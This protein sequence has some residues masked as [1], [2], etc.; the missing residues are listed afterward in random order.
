MR[1]FI[2]TLNT[3]ATTKLKSYL[4]DISE[5]IRNLK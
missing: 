4:L 2:N 5:N 3:I 1:Y